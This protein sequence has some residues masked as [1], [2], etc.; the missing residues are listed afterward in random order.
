H[1]F[2]LLAGLA[3]TV[4]HAAVAFTPLYDVTVVPLLDPPEVVRAP[5]QLGL[6]LMLPWSWAIAYRRF[7]Q[8]L[9]IR[10]DRARHVTIGTVLRIVALGVV[11]LAAALAGA[12]G[13][14]A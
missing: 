5:A 10:N 11:L 2:M 6:Q 1:R 13:I 14:V 3:L 9:L 7:H 12:S 8:G 4:V